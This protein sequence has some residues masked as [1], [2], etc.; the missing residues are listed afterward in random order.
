MRSRLDEQA[1][2]AAEL[3]RL[4]ALG[5]GPSHKSVRAAGIELEQASARIDEYAGAWR[6]HREITGR[7]LS[8]PTQAGQNALGKAVDGLRDDELRLTQL[9]E[10]ATAEMK[11]LG[12]KRLRLQQAESDLAR[13]REEAAGLAKRSEVLQAEGA[14]GG[15]LSVISHGEVPLSPVRDSRLKCAL[16]GSAAGVCVPLAMLVALGAL[17]RP[18]RYSDETEADITPVAPLLGVL[19]DLEGVSDEERHVAAAHGVHQIRMVLAARA[20]RGGTGSYLVTSA[21]AGEGKTSLT[22]ALGLSFAAAGHRTLIVDC[23]LVGR[24]ITREL[25]FADEP[26]LSEALAEGAIGKRIRRAAGELYILPAGRAEPAQASALPAAKMATVLAEARKHFQVVLVDTG[27]VLGSLEAAVV[28]PEVD[29]AVLVVA[30]G[31]ERGLVRGALLRLRSLGV[32]PA[33]FVYNRA[34]PRDFS[35]SPYGSSS[36]NRSSVSETAASRLACAGARRRRLD[37]F[38]PLVTAVGRGATLQ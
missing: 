36:S 22:V 23:D 28:A 17:R 13:L 12:V 35:S 3:R 32:T 29:G 21:T 5:L 6:N 4:E 33:G 15:R 7:S 30:R 2:C 24:R 9:L 34:S 31:R 19:P 20:G 27:P 8:D 14:L 38:G 37:R 1:R 16:A 26:G 10:V 11:H 18:Y 25:E